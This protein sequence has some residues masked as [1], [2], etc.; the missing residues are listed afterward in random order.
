MTKEDIIRSL[1][2]S[3]SQQCE[4]VL[5]SSC[6]LVSDHFRYSYTEMPGELLSVICTARK[7]MRVNRAF[8]R[9][10]KGKN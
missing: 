7:P 2:L 9:K 5:K 1:C 10:T 6:R 3:K 8:D 4:L